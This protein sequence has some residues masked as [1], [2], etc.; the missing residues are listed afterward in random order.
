[1]SGV[2]LSL[3]LL[4]PPARLICRFLASFGRMQM[5]KNKA[6]SRASATMPPRVIPAIA[7][8]L[9][10]DDVDGAGM[11]GDG[12]EVGEADETLGDEVVVLVVLGLLGMFEVVVD[13]GLAIEPVVT[14]FR[15]ESVMTS[16][17][18]LQYMMYWSS[19]TLVIV[20]QEGA[21]DE[22]CCG[23]NISRICASL[24]LGCGDMK[25]LWLEG[26]MSGKDATYHTIQ[27]P[28][29][30]SQDEVLVAV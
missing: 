6:D 16:A 24:G 1:M 10:P 25:R 22:L 23:C 27:P 9:S 30:G 4:N 12:D 3:L 28:V 13:G 8:L 20:T 2:P 11:L 19:R 15:Y 29:F 18:V 17:V 7:S 5:S 14:G 26:W 21:S